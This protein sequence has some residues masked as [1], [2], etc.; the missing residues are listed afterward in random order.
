MRVGRGSA[1]AER[2]GSA[3]ILVRKMRP[4]RLARSLSKRKFLARGLPTPLAA[5]RAALA[6]RVELT[7]ALCGRVAA[8]ID[9]D[10]IGARFHDYPDLRLV[11]RSVVRS[12]NITRR[13]IQSVACPEHGRLQ[14]K[15]KDLLPAAAAARDGEVRSLRLWPTSPAT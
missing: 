10:P 2:P 7:C 9:E 12:R 1:Y 14:A 6:R 13:H 8:Y 4:G 15:W 3:G 11:A 5:K